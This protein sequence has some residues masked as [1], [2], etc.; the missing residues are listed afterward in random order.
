MSP[1]HAIA[2]GAACT[3][4]AGAGVFGLAAIGATVAPSLPKI[5]DALRG[6]GGWWLKDN[7]S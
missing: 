2:I 3:L 7:E 6:V 1:A 4:L 5:S